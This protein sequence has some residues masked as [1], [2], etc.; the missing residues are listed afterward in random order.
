MADTWQ[1]FEH[2]QMRSWL[3]QAGLVNVIVTGT[4][5]NC[6]AGIDPSQDHETEQ[7]QVSISTFVAVG[8]RRLSGA[9]EAV[10]AGYGATAEGKAGCC[11]SPVG[12]GSTSCCSG[13]SAE[14]I[15]LEVVQSPQFMLGYT[16]D[17]LGDAPQEAVEISLGCGNPLALAGLQTGEFV[18]DIG[19]GGG[20]DA[21]L[22]ARQVGPLGRVIGVDMTPAMLERARNTA[23]RAGYSQVEFRQ[24]QAEALPVADNQVDVVIS[25]CVINLCEDKGQVFQEAYRVLK[26]GGQAGSK[27]HGYQPGFPA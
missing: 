2:D 17:V 11:S 15:S 8:T 16:P 14:L 5:E 3:R 13:S 23:E 18:L 1:G 27:R 20:I 9:R 24:G 10:Q 4:G 25:N 6:H 22:A 12:E 21:F 7:P 19:S 26:S